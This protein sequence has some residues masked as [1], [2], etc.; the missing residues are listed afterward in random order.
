MIFFVK[1]YLDTVMIVSES[2]SDRSVWDSW[3]MAGVPHSGHGA[4]SLLSFPRFYEE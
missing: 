2:D 4:G 1:C 3:K